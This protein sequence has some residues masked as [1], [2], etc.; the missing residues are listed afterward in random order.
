MNSLFLSAGEIG[1]RLF[2]Q[3]GFSTIIAAKSIGD[4]CWINQ[5]VTIGYS[6]DPDPPIIGKGVRICAGAMVIGNI[7]VG[8][9]SIVAANATVVKNVPPNVVVAGVPAKI[10]GENMDH[11]LYFG[12]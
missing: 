3:H 8:D 1:H 7:T 4:D 11:K 10:V 12:A 6:F 2:I 5:Q 9:N